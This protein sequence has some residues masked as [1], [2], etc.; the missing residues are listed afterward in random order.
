MILAVYTK[1]K[2]KD[3]WSLYSLAISMEIAKEHSKEAL[4]HAKDMGY[5][6]PEAIVQGYTSAFDI[7][8]VLEKVKPEKLFYN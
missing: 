7:P 4:K 2:P 1:N 3:K 5:D 6:E 8:K